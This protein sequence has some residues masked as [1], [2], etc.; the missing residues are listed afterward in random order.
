MEQRMLTERSLYSRNKTLVK[1]RTRNQ[2]VDL[3]AGVPQR[4]SMSQQH[5][6]L[7]WDR[8]NYKGFWRT[9]LERYLT[10]AVG[11]NWDKVYSDLRQMFSGNLSHS[12]LDTVRNWVCTNAYLASD[13]DVRFQSGYSADETTN[14]TCFRFYVHPVT[15]SLTKVVAKT[16]GNQE[17][18]SMFSTPW[19]RSQYREDYRE[20]TADTQLHCVQGIWYKVKLGSI[21]AALENARFESNIG[22]TYDAIAH[23]PLYQV[24][25]YELKQ[26]YGKSDVYGV[27]KQQLSTQQLR[28]YEL[29]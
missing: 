28:K 7:S 4:E 18:R 23:K 15:R 1:S 16:A 3:E 17:R 24:M 21:S 6:G 26:L 11:Q 19:R 22:Y 12:V 25:G 20:L 2:P 27:S 14:E 8:K 13:G 10:K 29:I 9:P 5:K